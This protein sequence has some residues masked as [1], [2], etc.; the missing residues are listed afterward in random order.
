M[1]SYNQ[2]GPSHYNPMR[3]SIHLHLWNVNLVL[4]MMLLAQL[5]WWMWHPC[6]SDLVTGSQRI[7]GVPQKV[8]SVSSVICTCTATR[9]Q[10]SGRA[11]EHTCDTLLKSPRTKRMKKI[12]RSAMSRL[13]HKQVEVTDQCD[14][15][16]E[17]WRLDPPLGPHCMIRMIVSNWGNNRLWLYSLGGPSGW[18]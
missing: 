11:T 14:W 7:P 3:V 10:R 13:F 1:L 12:W 15:W 9:V 8:I 2:N 6:Q 5:I 17:R 18:P 16:L 4:Q